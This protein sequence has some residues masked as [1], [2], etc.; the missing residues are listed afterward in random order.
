MKF[1]EPLMI[2]SPSS[3]TAVVRMPAASLPALASVSPHAPS[4]SPRTRRGR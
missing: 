2:H 3:W 4:T 1:F